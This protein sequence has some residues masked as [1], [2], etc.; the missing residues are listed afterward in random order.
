MKSSRFR[1]HS[2]AALLGVELNATSH[3]EKFIA[4]LGALLGVLVVAVLSLVVSSGMRAG[5]IIE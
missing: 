5:V 1:L 2:L 3:Q 4:S